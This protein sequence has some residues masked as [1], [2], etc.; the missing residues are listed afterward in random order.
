MRGVTARVAK[1]P[2][3]ASAMERQFARIKDEAPLLVAWRVEASH[4]TVN[5]RKKRDLAGPTTS[6]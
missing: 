6:P 1:L 4:E 2:R 5:S 3:I